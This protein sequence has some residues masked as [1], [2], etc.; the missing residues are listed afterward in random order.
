VMLIG[1]VT[2]NGILIVEFAN[3]RREAGQS[4][5]DA[6]TKAAA[7][8]LRPI[9]MTTLCAI[10][11]ILP[12]ALS[13]GASSKARAPMGVAVVAGLSTALVFTLIVVPAMYILLAPKKL[14]SQEG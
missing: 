14:S 1:L 4:V 10:L 6:V 3:Q 11:G 5:R 8:R 2:K 13:L 12:I 7:A 9:L